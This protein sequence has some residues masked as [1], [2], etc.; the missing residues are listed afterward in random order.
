MHGL[1]GDPA[2]GRIAR[3]VEAVTRRD[4]AAKLR[5][6]AEF[7]TD[8]EAPGM[9]WGALVGST[10]AHGRLR[11]LDLE[12]ARRLPG[13]VAVVGPSELAGLLPSGKRDAER[14]VFPESILRYRHEPVAAVAART[15]AEARAAARAVRVEVD[16]LPVVSEIEDVFPEWPGEE[17]PRSPHVIAHVRA[18][19]GDVDGGFARA[20]FVHREVYRTN[21]VH[22]VALEPHAC[23]AEVNDTT[24]KVTTSTQTPFGVREDTAEILG[25]KED[26]L[27]VDGSWVGGGF[28]GKAAAFLEP[29][30]LVLARA[31]RKPVR[32]ALTYREEFELGRTTL[33][34]IVWLDTAVRGGKMTAR[35][36]RLLLD[37]GASL[38]GRDFATGY[39]IAFLLGPYEVPAFELEGYALRT[40]KPP[41]GPHRAPLAPQTAFI[42]ES[43][44][45]SIARRL[46]R[47]PIDFRLAHV[48]SEGSTTPLGQKVGPF[49]AA[50]ALRRAGRLAALWRKGLKPHQGVGV[51]VG[52]WGTGVGAGGEAL[53]RLTADDLSVLQVEHD[54]GNGSVVVGLPA[55]AERVLGLPS[56]T[57]RVLTADTASA[58]YDSGVFGSRTVAAL[59]QAVEK[60]A[61]QIG[62]TLAKRMGVR[63]KVRLEVERGQFFA[64]AGAKR[65]AVRELLT[66]D[67]RRGGGLVVR[68]RHYGKP[69]TI[70]DARVREGTF[71]AYHDFAASV[72]LAQVEVDRETG[73]VRVMRATAF[74]DVGTILDPEMVRSQV[75]GA[76]VMGLGTALSEET[77]WGPDGRM[78]NPGLLDYRIPTLGDVPPIEVD[79]VEGFAGAGPFGLKG[80]GEPPII[81]VP[82]AVANAVADATGARVTELPLTAERV[83]RALK[84]L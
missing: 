78:L 63:A 56:G 5:G 43:H 70:D 51:G 71:Y 1:R 61:Q 10:V 6:T 57:V 38:P 20:E 72:H 74:P 32:L 29:Y 76:V 81:P 46:G 41:F 40:N 53:L 62:T 58:P 8:L 14:P 15:L 17:G 60:A 64:V 26:Q 68:D 44:I 18:N 55:V 45:D 16:P 21:G 11:R 82:A 35:R 4:A 65:V 49:G 23:L 3:D 42:G 75:E 77:L 27:V 39:A 7:G 50:E 73:A 59:G 47:D 33:P 37:A 54:I 22:Q 36:V 25:L 48:W 24:W 84:L 34:S 30:A 9:V 67:E 28:G 19:H 66:P 12:P 31:C 13:V 83:A 80:L 69:G 79:P 2:G 52:F